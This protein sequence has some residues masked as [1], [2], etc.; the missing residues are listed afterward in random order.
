MRNLAFYKGAKQIM[1]DCL[2]T[3]KSNERR[4][5]CK[6]AIVHADRQINRIEKSVGIGERVEI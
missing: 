5:E 2:R 6:R 3:A 1:T 4:R